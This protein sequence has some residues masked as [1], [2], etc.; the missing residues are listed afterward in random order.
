MI[1]EFRR[2]LGYQ[3]L[4]IFRTASPTVLPTRATIQ[5][6]HF[7]GAK[8]KKTIGPALTPNHPNF[9]F[10]SRFLFSCAVKSRLHFSSFCFFSSQI[11]HLGE[12]GAAI[13][14]RRFRKPWL[15]FLY[16]VIVKCPPHNDSL[17]IRRE[18]TTIAARVVPMSGQ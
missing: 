5:R 18:T 2:L 6:Q 7:V 10:F 16:R 8:S 3:P 15:R 14:I 4:Y 11:K 9:V 1:I 12:T 17:Q 13:E